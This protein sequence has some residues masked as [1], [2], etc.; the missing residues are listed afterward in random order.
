MNSIPQSLVTNTLKF[1]VKKRSHLTARF[2]LP[3]RN[4]LSQNVQAG[5]T[6]ATTLT[7]RFGTDLRE[8]KMKPQEM[9]SRAEEVRHF[10]RLY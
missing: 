4:Q 5:S 1:S 3:S 7:H 10:S 9:V 6:A 8:P 2:I